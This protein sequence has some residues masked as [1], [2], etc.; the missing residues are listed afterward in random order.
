M[1]A[2]KRRQYGTGSVYQRKS[3]GRWLGAIQ[4]GWKPNGAR[5]TITVSAKTEAECKRRLERK[6]REIEAQ[7]LPETH[8]DR[9]TVKAWS[10]VWLTRVEH[11][12]RPRAF[13]SSRSAVKTWIV[14]TIGAKR[15][16]RL[17][18]GDVRAVTQA[19]R[20]AGLK[21]SSALR[22]HVVLVKMLR[23]AILEGYAVPE[24]VLL[25]ERPSVNVNDRAAMTAGQA[26][27]VLEVATQLP[28]AS[29][30]VAALLQGLRQGEA[31]GLTWEAV[32]RRPGFI[33]I[34]WQLQAL[35]YVDKRD[36]SRGFRVPDNFEARQL[37]GA[38]HLTR[39][40]TA[41]GKR[42]VPVVPWMANALEVW[43]AIAPASPY[44]LVWPAVDGGP[45]DPKRDLEEWKAL[46]T[47]AGVGHPAGRHYVGHEARHTTATLLLE[48]GVDP[49]IIKAIVGHSTIVS[50][51]AYLHAPERMT[52]EALG[53][54]AKRLELES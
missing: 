22:C 30:W 23:A 13:S 21:P 14:P 38:Y 9:A 25:V 54:V 33:D 11:Q 41:A 15:L 12:L 24:R 19:M 6:K 46:Q 44:G 7:G 10:E 40:K 20:D 8:A 35:P 27:A 29:R 26:I 28:H 49:E 5:R 2:R 53:R 42:I 1:S 34:S 52:A 16:Q 51:Q 36:H 43:R 47:T 4:A 31:L 17:T 48:A 50:T 37:E 32:D 18:P 3:D 39:P 45:A